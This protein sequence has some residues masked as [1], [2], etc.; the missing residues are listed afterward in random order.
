MTLQGYALL[1][2]ATYKEA[3]AAVATAN[4]T[5]FLGNKIK[6]DFAFVKGTS[7]KENKQRGSA[8]NSRRW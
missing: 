3:K 4:E 8:K 7:G 2:Y 6:V 5:E 1:E